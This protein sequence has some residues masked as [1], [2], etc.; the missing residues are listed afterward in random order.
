ML[1]A[2]AVPARAVQVRIVVSA[3]GGKRSG[4]FALCERCSRFAASIESSASV[5][6]A[7]L[8]E[9]QALLR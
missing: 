5:G 3:E 1:K 7:M 4:E 6:A 2:G 9:L 8:A